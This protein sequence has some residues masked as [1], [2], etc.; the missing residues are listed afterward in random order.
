MLPYRGAAGPGITWSGRVHRSALTATAM[1]SEDGLWTVLFRMTE[2]V[3]ETQ[4]KLAA[5]EE[6]WL[7][8]EAMRSEVGG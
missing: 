6:R 1:A 8:L 5:N 2:A 3:A 4:A 7:A